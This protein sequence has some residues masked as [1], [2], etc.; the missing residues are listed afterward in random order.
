MCMHS[1]TWWSGEGISALINSLVGRKV[2]QT[3]DV[4]AV[5]AETKLIEAGTICGVDVRIYDTQGVLD[6]EDEEEMIFFGAFV[7]KGLIC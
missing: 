1:R 7:A 3:G 4:D 2:C 6:G 5:T